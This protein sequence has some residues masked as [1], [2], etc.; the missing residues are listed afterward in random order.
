MLSILIQLLEL[1]FDELFMKMKEINFE[2]VII[3]ILFLII[4]GKGFEGFD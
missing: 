4:I 3:S 2:T 1:I